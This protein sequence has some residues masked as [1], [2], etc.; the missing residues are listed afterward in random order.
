MTESNRSPRNIS[1]PSIQIEWRN[2]VDAAMDGIICIDEQQDIVLF[3]AAAE[4]IFDYAANDVLGHPITK[5]M[6]ERFR[7]KHRALVQQFGN[8]SPRPRRMDAKRTVRALRSNGDEFPIEAS[9][10]HFQSGGGKIYTAIVRDVTET[11]QNRSLIQQQR[12]MLDQVAD[13]IYAVDLDAKISYW[14]RA[15]EKLFGWSEEE[16]L[17]LD[18]VEL[19]HCDKPEALAEIQR[20]ID[21]EESWAGELLKVTRDG[22][23]FPAVH[24]QMATM[25]ESGEVIGYLCITRDVTIRHRQDLEQRRSQRLESIGTLA[26]GIA[27]DLNNLLTPILMG[28]K[29]LNSGKTVNQQEI[30][31]TMVSSAERGTLLVRQL[32][33]FAGGLRGEHKPL[34]IDELVSETRSI[35][36]HT[37]PKSVQIET[38]STPGLPEVQGDPTEISQVLMNLCINARDAMPA[39]GVLTIEVASVRLNETKKLHPDACPGDYVLLKVTDNGMGMTTEVQD[40]IFSPFYTTKEIG[41]G[42]GIGLATV[43]GIVK[44]H[45]GFVTVYSEPGRGST[46]CVYLPAISPVQSTLSTECLQTPDRSG[47]GRTLLLV[48]DEAPIR[49]MTGIALESAG[50]RVLSAQNGMEAVEIFE[51]YQPKIS[52]VVLDMMMPGMDGLQVIDK[53]KQIDPHVVVVACTGLQTSDREAAAMQHGAKAFVAKPYSDDAILATLS[54]L[55]DQKPVNSP[56]T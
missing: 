1:R 4:A 25:A 29:L 6:P 55:L 9:I 32:L 13:P 17:G 15:A 52:A 11:T 54:D 20:V 49:Q 47:K 18:A 48:D 16:V 37:L 3:N 2:I 19:L 7:D 31:K 42:T 46:F 36:E 40:R 23:A 51:Q 39:G 38:Y 35:L 10:S 30:L 44:S 27:H 50:Y 45:K 26:G 33:T 28:A 8:E 5:L 34:K 56:K 24:Y 41:K 22:R 14:N 53:L 12:Q 21:V 43:Q